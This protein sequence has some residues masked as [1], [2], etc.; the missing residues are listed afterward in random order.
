MTTAQAILETRRTATSLTLGGVAVLAGALLTLVARGNASETADTSQQLAVIL[1]ALGVAATGAIRGAGARRVLS[2]FVTGAI[3]IGGLGMVAWDVAPS[4]AR[5][6]PP[7][8]ETAFV[9]AALLLSGGL[10][11][12]IFRPMRG[13]TLLAVALDSAILFCAVGVVTLALW[14]PDTDYLDRAGELPALGGAVLLLADSGAALMALYARRVQ[15]G[16]HG[17]WAII[18]GSTLLGTSWIGWIDLAARGQGAAVAPAGFVF[19]I[20]VLLLAHGAATWDE[21][22]SPSARFER[23]AA[24]A[25]VVF[26]LSA[27][28]IAVTAYVVAGGTE[29]LAGRATI[30]TVAAAIART[31]MLLR[32][33][34]SARR[35]E[36]EA[37]ARLAQELRD[38][39]DTLVSLARLQPGPTAADTALRICREALRLPGA[40]AAVIRTVDSDGIVVPLAIAG[41]D[42]DA[43]GYLER[44]LPVA[45][46]AAL[47]TRAADNAWIDR[48]APDETEP[49]LRAL[50][51]TGLRGLV[52]APLR[53]EGRLAGI[54]SLGVYSDA[55]AAQ[56]PDRIA[57]TR[58]LGVVAGA[59]LGPQLASR[60][61]RLAVQRHVARVID[62]RAFEP[63]FQPIVELTAHRIVGFEALTRFADG[64]RPDLRFS[65]AATVEL[66]EQLE[67]AT[68]RAALVSASCLPETAWLSLNVSPALVTAPD[69]LGGILASARRPVVLEITEHVPIDDYDRLMAALRPLRSQARIAVDDAGAGYAGLRH[70]LELRPDYVKLDRALVRSIDRDPARRALASSLASFARETGS[71]LIAE[72]IETREE[73]S[74][75]RELGVGLGQGYL[76]GRPERLEPPGDA[77]IPVIAQMAG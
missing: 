2:T 15:P 16:M 27:V 42:F 61:R 7:L 73:L 17:P 65:E 60:D 8:S 3:L 23:F 36:H 28:L 10:A 56:L 43:T 49:G 39:G 31:A 25:T 45:R 54:V 63:V 18:T 21:R 46:A 14:Q 35:A 59:L 11:Y 70:I 74:V 9:L 77:V 29:P 20:G 58:E 71:T 44:P 51:D 66:G 4:I 75:L 34:R 69:R 6:P 5:E 40:E 26:P 53:W 67:T 68:L 33:E 55:A 52:S 48:I 72:G 12:G 37:A 41:T 19:S 50:A 76:L 30:G 13:E 32:S 24:R 57:T 47:R 62:E 38:R 64:T 22:R 1:A